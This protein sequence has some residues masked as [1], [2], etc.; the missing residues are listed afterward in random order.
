MG[1][2][3][4]LKGTGDSDLH[5]DLQIPL[6]NLDDATFQGDLNIK[7]GNLAAD[8]GMGMPE[9]SRINGHLKFN[10]KGL[11]A[12]NV[13]LLLFDNPAQ[14]SLNTRSDKAVIIQGSGRMTDAAL[15]KL[16]NNLLTRSLQGT[17]DWKASLSSRNPTSA[18]TSAHNWW[19]WRPTCLARSTKVQIP[20]PPAYPPAPGK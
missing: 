12:Q 7:N 11:Q 5:L 2:T 15:R 6:E 1:F 3:E 16:D 8:A 20:R 14:I 4:N 10:E 9:M 19:G 13:Q 17:T 18:W